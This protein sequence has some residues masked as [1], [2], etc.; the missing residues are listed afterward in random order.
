MVAITNQNKKTKMPL[1]HHISL[2]KI[3]PLGG[4]LREEIL[5]EQEEPQAIESLEDG[6]DEGALS[7]FWNGVEQDIE[8]DPEWFKFSED[9]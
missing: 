8:K 4:G 2:P 6:V 7:Q 5:A 3:D 9:E 1:F